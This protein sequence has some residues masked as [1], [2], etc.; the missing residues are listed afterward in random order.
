MTLRQLQLSDFPA[1]FNIW[2]KEA[3]AGALRLLYSKEE[4][5]VKSYADLTQVF[6]SADACFIGAEER[7]TLVAAILGYGN[8]QTKTYH[9]SFLWVA[10]SKR[11]LRFGETLA[12]VLY[13]QAREKGYSRFAVE[14]DTKS[15]PIKKILRNLGFHQARTIWLRVENV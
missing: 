7:S 11:N 10:P 13:K 15:V 14:T 12:Q 6:D 9:C 5:F 3:Y 4:F 8:P 1:I 2:V